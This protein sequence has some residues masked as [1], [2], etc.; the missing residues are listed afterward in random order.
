MKFIKLFFSIIAIIILLF[1]I[2]NVGHRMGWGEPV[3]WCSGM[4]GPAPSLTGYL[5]DYFSG[6]LRRILFGEECK[7]IA[8]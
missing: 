8:Y 5:K 2:K 6:S 4:P 3:E 1:T 7:N